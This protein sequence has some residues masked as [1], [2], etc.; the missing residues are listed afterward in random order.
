M[1]LL[2]EM[3]YVRRVRDIIFFCLEL[4]SFLSNTVLQLINRIRN[5]MLGAQGRV[6][7]MREVGWCIGDRPELLVEPAT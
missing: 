3:L 4:V 7:D 6:A 1:R 2:P 5:I